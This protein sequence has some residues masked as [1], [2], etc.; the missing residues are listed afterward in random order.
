MTRQYFRQK[1]KTIK[2]EISVNGEV[3]V[4]FPETASFDSVEK[5]VK[6][7]E[8]WIKKKVDE[9]TAKYCKNRDLFDFENILL[10]G[11][12]VKIEFSDVKKVCFDDNI[13]HFPN[14]YSSRDG[15]FLK[16]LKKFIQ[17]LAIEIL[18]RAVSYFSEI[19]GKEPTKVSVSQQKSIWGQCN[20]KNEIRLN[21]KLVMLKK[22]LMEYVV[23][24]ELCHMIEF[25]HSKAFWRNIDEICDSKICKKELKEFNFLVNLF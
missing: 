16:E 17:N 18:P 15:E 13:L 8:K 3:R 12:R 1:R 10:F 14:K 23:V 19:V 24:H 2:I 21:A 22:E 4:F 7:K 25:N 5:F 9:A 20:N 11:K 6:K